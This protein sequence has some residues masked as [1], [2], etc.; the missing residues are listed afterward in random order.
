MAKKYSPA[1]IIHENKPDRMYAMDM[2]HLAIKA[3]H[4]T[5]EAERL[6]L[7]YA[8]C[9]NGFRPSRR[10]ICQDARIHAR[11]IYFVRALLQQ[12]GFLFYDREGMTVTIKWNRIR[13]YATLDRKLT[14]A[15]KKSNVYVAEATKDDGR[16]PTIGEL[17]KQWKA[18]IDEALLTP[19]QRH[20]YQAISKMT[21]EEWNNLNKGLEVTLPEVMQIEDDE[22]N[23]FYPE[24]I[25]GVNPYS[26]ISEMPWSG[27][28]PIVE[29][30]QLP[31]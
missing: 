31:F 20:F 12:N 10:L 9:E 8:Q 29:T 11:H 28:L 17:E 2:V 22:I 6:M 21:E 14:K 25:N 4:L 13:V 7:Y 30:Y 16:Q 15:K 24:T 26:D 27:R 3:L 18:N 23:H 5:W 19:A 1:M